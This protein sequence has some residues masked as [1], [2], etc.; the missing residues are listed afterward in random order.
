MQE[1]KE[2]IKIDFKPYM[3]LIQNVVQQILDDGFIPDHVAAIAR[4][5]LI[6]GL[7]LS[8]LLNKPLPVLGAEH[9]P[10]GIELSEVDFARHVLYKT[11]ISKGMCF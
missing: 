1:I 11:E 9:W 6:I 8:Y 4:G 5:G 3:E 10:E 7:R 2:A